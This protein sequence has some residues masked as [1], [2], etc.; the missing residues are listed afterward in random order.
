MAYRK[1]QHNVGSGDI[2]LNV[3]AWL[4]TDEACAHQVM[5]GATVPH[6]C[7]NQSIHSDRPSTINVSFLHSALSMHYIHTCLYTVQ[8]L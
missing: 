7:I 5:L 6:S 3:I 1:G 8:E 4:V 2:Q